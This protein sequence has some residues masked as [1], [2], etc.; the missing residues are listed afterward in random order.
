MTEPARRSVVHFAM[1]ATAVGLCAFV[2]VAA[3]VALGGTPLL[4]SPVRADESAAIATLKNIATAQRAFRDAA[5]VDRDG[6]GIGEFGSFGELAGSANL[7][8]ASANSG[9]PLP[10][11]V[12]LLSRAFATLVDGCVER[13][14][15]RFRLHLPS[16]NGTFVSDAFERVCANTAETRFCIYAWPTGE[17]AGKRVFF[18]DEQDDVWASRNDDLRYC[19]RERPIPVDAALPSSD[20]DEPEEPGV[21]RGRDGALWGIVN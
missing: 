5:H 20:A 18:V 2:L 12:P 3:Y 17:S 1:R 19:G 7:R 11:S 13:S 16:G 4:C 8:W 9:A 6:D 15:Y 10:L 14:G 21:R